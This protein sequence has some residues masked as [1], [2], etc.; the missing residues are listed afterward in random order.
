[1]ILWVCHRSHLR[2]PNIHPISYP[3]C[4]PEDA[5]EALP[6]SQVA[7]QQLITA[8]TRCI[9]CDGAKHRWRK[10]SICLGG[11]CQALLDAAGAHITIYTRALHSRT[12]VIGPPA[13]ADVE[14]AVPTWLV[15][16]TDRPVPCHEEP[17]VRSRF[18]KVLKGPSLASGEDRGRC[19]IGS[20]H[21][22]TSR[23]SSVAQESIR[24]MRTK[25]YEQVLRGR[26]D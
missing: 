23:P 5:K 20:Q 18:H 9:A 26:S 10:R 4:S 7:L 19:C 13:E 16:T 22:L 8:Q 1:M 11:R 25:Q 24:T 17:V 3:Q 15:I 6:K 2:G 21:V 12:G 14:E